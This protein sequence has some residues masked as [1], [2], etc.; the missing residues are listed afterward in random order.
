MRDEVG[1]FRRKGRKVK[2]GLPR[3]WSAHERA[4]NGIRRVPANLEGER[5]GELVAEEHVGTD[6]PTGGRLWLLRCDCGWKALRTTAHLRKAVKEGR[7][8]ACARCCAE[9]WAGLCIART[10]TRR[11]G[12]MYILFR[13]WEEC[14]V[15]YGAAYDTLFEASLRDA[16][17]ED[18]MYFENRESERYYEPLPSYEFTSDMIGRGKTPI[19]YFYPIG[20]DAG[21]PRTWKCADCGEFFDRGIGCTLCIEPICR[22]CVRLGHT[23]GLEHED[24]YTLRVIGTLFGVSRTRIL[25]IQKEAMRR[26]RHPS[27]LEI[28][29]DFL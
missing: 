10:E 15:L 6:E 14:G 28:F 19:T 20:P 24:G 1:L 21:P 13:L 5:F 26:L 18:G 4:D 17:E 27:R 16:F 29:R 3:G 8:P 2:R 11:T 12:S 7:Q 22:Q 23:C 9:L 25:E